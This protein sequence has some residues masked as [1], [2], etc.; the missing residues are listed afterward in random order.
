VNLIIEKP[1]REW[2]SNVTFGGKNLDVLYA[3]CSDKVYRRK[4]NA[5]GLLPWRDVVQPPRPGL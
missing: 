2:I 1:Q 3:T 5:K 4:I